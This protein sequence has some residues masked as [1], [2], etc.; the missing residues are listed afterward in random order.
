MVDDLFDVFLDFVCVLTSMFM[1]DIGL[2][3]S[4]EYLCGLDIRVTVAL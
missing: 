2:L 3:F 1:R 4:F